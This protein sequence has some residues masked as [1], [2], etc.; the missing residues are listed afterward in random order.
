MYNDIVEIIPKLFISNWF[1][2]NNPDV[3]DKYKI[4]A[5][6]TLETM[7]K[8][9][10][11]LDYYVHNNIKF[12]YIY[13]QDYLNADINQYFDSTYEF[14]K[15]KISIG[16]NVLVHCFAGISRSSTIILNYLIRNF[17]E[18]T[19]NIKMNPE[20]VVHYILD[21]VKEKRPIVE[22]NVGFLN[23]LLQKAI[24]YNNENIVVEHFCTKRCCSCFF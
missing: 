17:Y 13:I 7:R 16:E 11:V 18:H 10:E 8:P 19:V 15:N 6:I 24:E 2:S 5:V 4:K 22:P 20:E 3:L 14:I 12:K 9:K 21:K 1:T 23:Q